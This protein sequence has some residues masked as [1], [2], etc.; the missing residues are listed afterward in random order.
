MV[1][2][3]MRAKMGLG[4][5]AQVDTIIQTPEIRPGGSIDGIIECKGGSADFE[6]RGVNLELQALAEYEDSEGRTQHTWMDYSKVRVSG[7][8]TLSP[9]SQQTLQFSLPVPISSPFNRVGGQSFAGVRLRVKTKLD[10]PGAVDP[11][12]EDAVEIHGLDLHEAIVSGLIG[13]GAG[14]KSSDVERQRVR[15]SEL[16]FIQEVEFTA[17]PHHR[18]RVKELEVVFLTGHSDVEVLIHIDKKGFRRDQTKRFTI[19]HR[20]AW[21]YDWGM[22]IDEVV[23]EAT[24]RR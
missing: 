15:G 23:A 6:V 3:K 9:G 7:G 8:F 18:D 2:K 4:G 14:L 21:D 20:Q 11:G 19:Q 1:F 16:P 10:I 24:G 13:L 5:G 17:P 22:A 12:D